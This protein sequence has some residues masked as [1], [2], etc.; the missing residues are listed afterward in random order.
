MNKIPIYQGKPTAYL[1]HNI[2]D[3]LAKY[4]STELINSLFSE[5]QIVYSDENLKEIHRSAGRENEFLDLLNE[6]DAFHL[7]IVVDSQ[8][9]LTNQATVKQEDSYK[10]YKEYRDNSEIVYENLHRAMLLDLQKIYGGIESFSA[11]DIIE[12]QTA[13]YNQLHNHIL[14][15]I[16]EMKIY[17]PDSISVLTEKNDKM[18]DQFLDVANNKLI[19]EAWDSLS[20]DTAVQVYRESFNAGPKILNNIKPPNVLQQIHNIVQKSVSIENKVSIEKFFYLDKNPIDQTN[21]YFCYQKVNV[22]YS[23]LNMLG[24]Y[25]D[26][27]MSN[28]KRFIASQSDQ[29]HAGM[30]SFA[31][32][33]FSE[34][35][36]FLKKVEAAYE[37][38]GVTTKIVNVV[39]NR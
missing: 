28:D 4:K 34:D 8:F 17:F 11:E 10:I 23:M 31:D 15:Q 12:E 2:L 6:L 36:R 1:D 30:A 32:V 27:E 19:L 9:K 3:F 39:I 21:D 7:K 22:I 24:Y 14:K 37:F 18:R 20:N 13:S 26:S 29:G 38:L 35:K 33:F 5:Y 16:E 25:P